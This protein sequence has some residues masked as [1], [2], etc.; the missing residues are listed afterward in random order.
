MKSVMSAAMTVVD[1]TTRK[2]KSECY[3]DYTQ[4]ESEILHL[5]VPAT[6]TTYPNAL[7]VLTPLFGM[8][9]SLSKLSKPQ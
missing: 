5:K 1:I 7:K 8:K 9:R 6:L 2:E 4:L 3:M